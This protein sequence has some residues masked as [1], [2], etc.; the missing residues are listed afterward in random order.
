MKTLNLA[1]VGLALLGHVTTTTAQVTLHSTLGTH[2]SF[3][4][5]C[6]DPHLGILVPFPLIIRVFFLGILRVVVT[7]LIVAPPLL[8]GFST[9]Q[10]MNTSCT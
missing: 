10:G 2:F 4:N 9:F 8:G 3:G 1:H 7:F 5:G 6:T